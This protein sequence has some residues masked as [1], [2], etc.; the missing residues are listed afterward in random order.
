MNVADAWGRTIDFLRS[1]K[2]AYQLT[3]NSPV[4]RDVLIDLFKFCRMNETCFHADP[5]IH[6]VLEGRR[7]VA[8]RIQQHLHLSSEQLMA[9]YAG[10]NALTQDDSK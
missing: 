5:R 9:L 8:L 6:A 7:E 10:Q 3:F 2:R 1:R 4:G